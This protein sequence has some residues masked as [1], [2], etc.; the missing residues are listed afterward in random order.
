MM[1]ARSI[2][3]SILGSAGS[4]LGGSAPSFSIRSAGSSNAGST[5]AAAM[6]SRRASDSLNRCASSARRRCR[7]RLIRRDQRGVLPDRLAVLAPDQRERPAR[8][9]LARIPFALPVMQQPARRKA[10]AQAT[11]QLIGERTLGRAESPPCSTPPIDNRRSTR[12]S[13]RRPSSGERP[14]PFRSASTLS[15]SAS[16]AYQAS[17][18]NGNVTRGF[19][20]MRA[21]FI[22]NEKSTLAG[23][24]P[25]EIGAAAR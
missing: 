7:M 11:D 12:R 25:P 14:A 19:S 4:I 23:S 24:T 17:S 2:G 9:R 5:C 20:S 22:S 16:S 13:A 1:R 6:P 8:Q 10:V 21:I 18:E 15:P 3:S